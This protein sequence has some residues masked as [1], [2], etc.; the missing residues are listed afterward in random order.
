M[1][2]LRRQRGLK[3]LDDACIASDLLNGITLIPFAMLT[4]TVVYPKILDEI[5]KYPLFVSVAGL[6]AII[7]VITELYK[8][9]EQTAK[10]P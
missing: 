2:I 3:V 7:R 5:A 9:A 6:L 10:K 1:M 4:S 8:G